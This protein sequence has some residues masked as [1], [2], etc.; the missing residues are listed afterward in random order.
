MLLRKVPKILHQSGFICL[1]A[2]TG[3]IFKH[4]QIN[5]GQWVSSIIF[6]LVFWGLFSLIMS[7]IMF[8]DGFDYTQM[9]PA[10]II[11]QA[12]I[13]SAMANASSIAKDHQSGLYQRFKSMPVSPISIIFSRV[14]GDM[15]KGIVAIIVFTFIGW[16]SGMH[17]YSGWCSIL[18]FTLIPLLFLITVNLGMGIIGHWLKIQ[19]HTSAIVSMIYAPLMMI[20]TAFAPLKSFPEWIQPIVYYSPVTSVL[21]VMRSA[22]NG[23]FSAELYLIPL[24]N[25]LV[26]VIIFSAF[27]YHILRRNLQ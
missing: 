10:S 3:R 22:L 4:L 15:I 8:H 26:L 5:I 19:E 11:I 20:S 16:V 1:G 13:F 18:L 7:K 24:I 6:P 17:F 14:F 12:I 21:S 27:Q 9:L 25:L 23:E 2:L